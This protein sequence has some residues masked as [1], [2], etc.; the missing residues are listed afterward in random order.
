M[1]GLSR[2]RQSLDQP[3]GRQEK[4]R[5]ILGQIPLYQCQLQGGYLQGSDLHPNQDKVNH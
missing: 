3:W 4:R 1:G 5:I 2:H